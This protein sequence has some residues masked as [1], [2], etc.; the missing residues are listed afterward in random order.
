MPE[1]AVGCFADRIIHMEQIFLVTRVLITTGTLRHRSARDGFGKV[2]SPC[3]SS[4]LLSAHSLVNTKMISIFN[5]NGQYCHNRLSSA[6]L[7]VKMAQKAAAY[8]CVLRFRDEQSQRWHQRWI[9]LFLSELISDH[10]LINSTLMVMISSIS[11]RCGS[12]P[13]L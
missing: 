8:F 10:N 1:S 12:V 2:F 3:F 9:R 6:Q 11:N 13:R 5:A 4:G 7:P